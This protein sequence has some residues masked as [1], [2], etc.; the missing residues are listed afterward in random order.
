MRRWKR[1]ISLQH[2]RT[3]LEWVG[4]R[5][6]LE[7]TESESELK[8]IKGWCIFVDSVSTTKAVRSLEE[9]TNLLS[10]KRNR[11]DNI[12]RTRNISASHV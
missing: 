12:H 2:D 8:K 6:E 1:D 9:F 11:K 5:R 3:V 7:Q 4:R 10:K